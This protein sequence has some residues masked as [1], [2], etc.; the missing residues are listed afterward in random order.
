MT[1]VEAAR[2]GEV[3][4]VS[5]PEKNVAKLPADLFDG[6]PDDVVVV[7]TGNYYPQQRDGRIDPIEDGSYREP[8]G[9]R[10]PRPV[11]W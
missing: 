3:V 9:G 4:I 2:S 5:I 1:V 10:P 11:R 6:V 8:V 7:D